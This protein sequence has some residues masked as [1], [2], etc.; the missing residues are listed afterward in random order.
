MA[1]H[2]DE[3]ELIKVGK[4]FIFRAY[5]RTHTFDRFNRKNKAVDKLFSLEHG[6]QQHVV[7][8]QRRHS[9]DF[10]TGSKE[11]HRNEDGT[12]RK[13][14]RHI[15]RQ[16][17]RQTDRPTDRHIDGRHTNRHTNRHIHTQNGQVHR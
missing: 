11:R 10:L 7:L 2:C 16:T 17:D 3:F 12:D 1:N 13:G 5:S 15:D 4:N 8:P 6:I 14:F 9:L